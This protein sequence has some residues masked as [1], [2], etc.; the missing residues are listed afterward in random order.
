MTTDINVTTEAAVKQAVAEATR[1]TQSYLAQYG[2]GA[3]GFSWVDVYGVRSNSVLGKAL[4][5]NGFRK[6]SY[7]KSLKFWSPDKTY[8]QSVDA[9]EAGA[10]AFV[11]VMRNTFSDIKI[12]AGSRLD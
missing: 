4:I 7:A 1:T 12:Y 9:K 11:D 2:E 5:A 8:T 3:C 10:R 6:D